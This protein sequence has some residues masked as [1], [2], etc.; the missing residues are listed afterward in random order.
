MQI[1]FNSSEV[2]CTTRQA[3]RELHPL[4][5]L[6]HIPHHPQK[7][8]TNDI[9]IETRWY[10]NPPAKSKV[11]ATFSS[12]RAIKYAHITFACG[13]LPNSSTFLSTASA[14]R[15]RSFHLTPCPVRLRKASSPSWRII[16]SSRS[17]RRGPVRLHVAKKVLK[18]RPVLKDLLANR[19]RQR[20]HHRK[21]VSE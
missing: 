4:D 18:Q 6:F 17:R 3:W 1:P 19:Q 13:K 11:A 9:S 15:R 14:K 21:E 7:A 2:L 8:Q 10:G 16:S 12:F 5:P 20:T